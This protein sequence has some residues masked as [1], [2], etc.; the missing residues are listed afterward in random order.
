MSTLKRVPMRAMKRSLDSI[1][2]AA[3]FM[4]GAGDPDEHVE[5]EKEIRRVQKIVLAELKELRDNDKS[6]EKLTRTIADIRRDVEELKKK[7]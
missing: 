6:I 2:D 4:L 1:F 5:R 3:V 7:P